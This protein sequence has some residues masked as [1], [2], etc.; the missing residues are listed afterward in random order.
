MMNWT[1]EEIQL[2]LKYTW[3]ISR[4]ASDFKTNFIIRIGDGQ[5]EGKGEVAP[6]VRYKETPELIRQQFQVFA[7]D[8]APVDSLSA[9]KTRLDQS[10]VCNALR[11]GIES[12]FIHYLCHRDHKTIFE[13]LSIQQPKAVFTAYTLPIMEIGEIK[14]FI[15]KNH[16]SRFRFI[17]IKI[18]SEEGLA[19]LNEVA[20]HVH[21]PLMVDANEDWKD[22]EDLIRFME[23]IKSRRVQFIEQPLPASFEEEYLHLKKHSLFELIADESITNTADFNLLKRQFHGVNMKLMKAGGYLNGLSILSNARNCGMKTMIGCMVETTLGISSAMH[24]CHG[25][26]YVDLDGSLILKNDPFHL[27]GEREGQLYFT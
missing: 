3:K 20:R 24:L 11:F 10:T 1:L 4:N 22:V 21:Q 27:H 12:A 9:L 15:A 26:D 6:N 25:L 2:E 16:L 23:K 18:N 17:K 13:V 14:E 5:F 19:T 7:L 8:P